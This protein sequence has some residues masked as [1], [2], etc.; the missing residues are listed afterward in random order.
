MEVH[1][2]HMDGLSKVLTSDHGRFGTREEG[3]VQPEACCKP[4]CGA[5]R[6][7]P[8]LYWGDKASISN[9]PPSY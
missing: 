7:T 8:S 5:R 9:S 1:C 6:N 3:R 2:W 4:G